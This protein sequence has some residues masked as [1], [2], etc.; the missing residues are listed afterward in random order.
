MDSPEFDILTLIKDKEPDFISFI[1]ALAEE[2]SVA[3]LKVEVTAK[4]KFIVWA[5]VWYA[6]ERGVPIK[7]APIIER[8]FHLASVDSSRPSA[9]AITAGAMNE[10]KTGDRFPAST[11]NGYTAM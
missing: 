10:E 2:D 5:C 1:D 3:L 4:T 6:L 7:V 9:E 8:V 11:D